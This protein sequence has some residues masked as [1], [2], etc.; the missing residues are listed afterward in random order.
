M[1]KILLTLSSVAISIQLIACPVCERQ[2]PKLLRGII[3]G[4]GPE[5]DIDY[6]IV[7]SFV[8]ITLVALF[9]SIKYLV[10]PGEKANNHIKRN[11]LDYE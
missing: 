9:Y 7:W 1:K 6:F 11:I 5:K 3:H 4:S 2:Q 10:H 8:A